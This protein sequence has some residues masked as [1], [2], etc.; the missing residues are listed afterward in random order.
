MISGML[1]VGFDELKQRELHRRHRRMALITIA[2]LAGM[3]I[4]G[5]K[6]LAEV[7]IGDTLTDAA[8]PA[9]EALP[10][11]EDVKPMVFSGG[12][13]AWYTD[14][15]DRNFTLWPYSAARFLA[16]QLRVRRSEFRG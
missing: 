11:F 13:N 16:E 14:A 2:S 1:G 5:V 10:G 12:C 6:T 3:V 9:S 8:N 15:N 7:R 4:A